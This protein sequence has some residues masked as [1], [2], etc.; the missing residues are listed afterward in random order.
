MVIILCTCVLAR[1][2]SDFCSVVKP[3]VPRGNAVPLVLQFL[4]SY[5]SG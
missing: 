4:H 3:G 2:L 1:S 5:F